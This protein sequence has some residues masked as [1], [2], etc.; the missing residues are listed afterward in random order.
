MSKF[1]EHYE[2]AKPQIAGAV[3]DIRHKLI[4]EG[5]FGRK[6][7]GDIAEQVTPETKSETATLSPLQSEV[8]SH[9]VSD[10]LYEEMWG[11]EATHAQIYGQQTPGHGSAPALAAPEP[12][13]QDRGLEPE[14]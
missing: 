4:E 1:W 7:T 6:V 2:A 9:G 11:K 5:W 10:A 8:V 14:V 12:P 3:D 13:Q